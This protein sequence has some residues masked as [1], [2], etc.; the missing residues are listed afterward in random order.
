MAPI[1]M[2][3]CSFCHLTMADVNVTLGK[4]GMPPLVC[5]SLYKYLHILAYFMLMSQEIIG[6]KWAMKC[7]NL[8]CC[9]KVWLSFLNFNSNYYLLVQERKVVKMMVSLM[10]VFINYCS[11]LTCIASKMW[12]LL[13]HATKATIFSYFI[14]SYAW[15]WTTLSSEI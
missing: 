15:T 2:E 6:V 3:C 11:V 9:G 7:S 12:L 5:G 1:L 14:K 13:V 10:Y 8:L 4:N